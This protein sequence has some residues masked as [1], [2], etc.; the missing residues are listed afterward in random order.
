MAREFFICDDPGCYQYY[1]SNCGIED[2]GDYLCPVCSRDGEYRNLHT[3]NPSSDPR[4]DICD[5]DE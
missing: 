4:C 3:R 1:C 5:A 2:D